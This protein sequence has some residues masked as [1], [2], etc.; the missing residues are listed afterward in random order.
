MIVLYDILTSH[1]VPVATIFKMEGLTE[2]CSTDENDNNRELHRV[3]WSAVTSV[4]ILQYNSWSDQLLSNILVPSCV[5][6]CDGSNYDTS[7]HLKSIAEL[8]DGIIQAL[9]ASDDQEIPKK[10]SVNFKP[11]PG[12]TEYLKESYDASRMAFHEWTFH[13]R[14]HQGLVYERMKLT[15]AWFKYA[16]RSVEKNQDTL[17]AES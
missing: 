5:V 9:K 7:G 15:R 8:Y 12:W 4:T 10:N 6:H 16:Q 17:R 13:G 1:H 11:V 3:D 14:P 2:T